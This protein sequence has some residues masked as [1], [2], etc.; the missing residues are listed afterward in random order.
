MQ[1][2]WGHT[3]TFYA[4]VSVKCLGGDFKLMRKNRM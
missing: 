2:H 4:P 1:N 3:D